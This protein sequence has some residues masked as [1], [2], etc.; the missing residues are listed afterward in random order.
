MGSD[1]ILLIILLAGTVLL[2]RE[3]LLADLASDDPAGEDQEPVG[4]D[5]K[6]RPA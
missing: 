5:K 2:N 1:A 4:A 6:N 3:V